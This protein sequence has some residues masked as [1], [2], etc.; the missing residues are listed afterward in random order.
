MAEEIDPFTFILIL[1]LLPFIILL[2]ILD[3]L[4]VILCE[5]CSRLF[6]SVKASSKKSAEVYLK[7]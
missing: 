7:Q 6:R 1:P 2:A 4:L 3:V 5:Y